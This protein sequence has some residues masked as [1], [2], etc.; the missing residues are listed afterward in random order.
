MRRRALVLAVLASCVPASEP[1]PPAGAAGFAVEP[2]PGARGTPFTTDDGWTLT[3]DALVVRAYVDVTPATPRFYGGSDD[4]LF[5]ATTRQEL[6][7]PAVPVGPA[8]VTA[9]LRGRYIYEGSERY[10]D[11]VL[12]FGVG[13]DVAARFSR[14]ADGGGSTDGPSVLLSVRGARGGRSVRLALAL[15]ADAGTSLGSAAPV[16][17]RESAV[18]LTDLEV[19]P[20]AV[21][22]GGLAFGALADADGDGDGEISADELRARPIETP[23]EGAPADSLLDALARRCGTALLRRRAP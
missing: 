2:S 5:D 4:F 19:A 3:V 20:E 22:G 9:Y 12:V 13:D 14:P 18:A 15:A 21:F 16:E 17:V 7:V 8:S 11:D 23:V 6:W 10:A 1:R